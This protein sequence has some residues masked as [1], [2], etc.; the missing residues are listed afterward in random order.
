MSYA[1]RHDGLGWRA[2]NGPD[3]CTTDE[4]W[5][6]TEP[7]M[8]ESQRQARDRLT[9]AVQRHLD[10][11]AQARGYDSILSACS[12]AGAPNPFQA[13]GAAFL[14]WRGVVWATCYQVL[15]DAQAG[16]RPIPADD[17]LIAELPVMVIP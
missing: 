16:A 14:A 9:S 17:E 11:T 2:V 8:V 1:L 15:A 13:E 4:T 7:V 5:Q 10:A 3:D 12:Y 6:A